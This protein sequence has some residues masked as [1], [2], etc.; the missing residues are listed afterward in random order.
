MATIYQIKCPD[1]GTEFGFGKGV[2]PQEA[3]Q[4]VPVQLREET[5]E[6]CPVCGREFVV[7]REDDKQFLTGVI[8]VD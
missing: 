8:F 4:P 1:C 3:D 6:K 2:M 5:P 7:T